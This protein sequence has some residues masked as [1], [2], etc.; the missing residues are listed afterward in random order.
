MSCLLLVLMAPQTRAAVRATTVKGADSG[1]ETSSFTLDGKIT[2]AESGKFTVNTEDNILFHVRYDDKT[3]IKRADGTDGSA[4]DLRV[5][6][7][8]HVVGDL[9]E[10]G[11]IAA[12][13]IKLQAKDSNQT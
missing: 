7:S 11:E 6:V 1:Q 8:V 2:Q 5:G 13:K 3:E 12:T 10:S 4:K 9:E